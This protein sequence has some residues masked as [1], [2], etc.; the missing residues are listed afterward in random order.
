MIILKRE[1]IW[2][3]LHPIPTLMM[4]PP[5]RRVKRGHVMAENY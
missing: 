5:E 3:Q 1:K 4:G 2:Q